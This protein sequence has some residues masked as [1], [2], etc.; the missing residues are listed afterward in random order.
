MAACRDLLVD[1][2]LPPSV[3]TRTSARANKAASVASPGRLRISTKV[4]DRA[5][6]V[7]RGVLAVDSRDHGVE[8]SF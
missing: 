2:Q 8:L 7:E 1:F 5:L 4:L 6:E 3:M